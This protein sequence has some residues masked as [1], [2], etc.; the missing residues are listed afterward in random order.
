MSFQLVANFR[1]MFTISRVLSAKRFFDSRTNN[2][3]YN[4]MY[5]IY[6]SSH[7][8]IEPRQAVDLVEPRNTSPAVDLGHVQDS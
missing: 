7:I 8:A 3:L 1:S 5:I 2:Y 4:C 6:I